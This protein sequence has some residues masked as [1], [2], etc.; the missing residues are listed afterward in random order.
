MVSENSSAINSLIRRATCQAFEE[1]DMD[2]DGWLSMS[3]FKHFLRVFTII[4]NDLSLCQRQG[5]VLDYRQGESFKV[6]EEE[7]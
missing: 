6:E 7:P 2:K 4:A 3:K 1:L 5:I